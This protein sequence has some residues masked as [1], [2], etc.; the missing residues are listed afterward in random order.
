MPR[1][2]LAL[3]N[4]AYFAV[5]LHATEEQDKSGEQKIVTTLQHIETGVGGYM[6][7]YVVN[8]VAEEEGRFTLTA[9]IQSRDFREHYLAH[10]D[11]SRDCLP[12]EE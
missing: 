2:I 6:P 12:R 3:D 9:S 11:L 1:K 4:R 5:D 8:E 10:F 7:R